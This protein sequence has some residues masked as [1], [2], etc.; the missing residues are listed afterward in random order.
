MSKHSRGF[1]WKLAF[2]NLKNN[3]R[4]Y[5]PYLLSSAGI[6]LMFYIICALV[7]GINQTT[8][9]GGT[10]VASM[11][12]LGQFVIGLFAVLFLFYTNSF[13]IKRRKKELGLYNIL[14]MEKQHIAKILFRETLL[15][16][17]ISLI[18]GLGLGILFS[19]VMFWLLGVMLGSTLPITF[20]IPG[21]AI[22]ATV[23]LF[24]CIFLLTL[25]YNLLQVKLSKP[26]E[27]LHGGE[28]G[29][30]E[31]KAHWI[32]AV[33]GAILLGTGYYMAVT[34]QDP[35]Q[36]LLFFFVAV[37][38]V[39]LGTYLLFI[40]GITALLKLLKKNKG[41]YYKTNHFTAISG[42]LFRMKQN[43]AGLAS[44]CV[45]F[46]ALLVTVSTTFSLYTSMDQLIRTRYPR[47][48]LISARGANEDA[49]EMIRSAVADQA[50]D[51]GLS[52]ENVVEQE[53][54]TIT[55]ARMGS[56][57]ST[58]EVATTTYAVAEIFTQ[59]EFQQF[60]GQDVEL[61]DNQVLFFDPFHTFP[62]GDSMTINNM[63]FSILTADYSFPD[64]STM[65]QIYETY[66]MVVKDA[67][68][69]NTII[70]GGD[71][72][73][74]ADF[75]PPTYSYDFDVAGGDPQDVK[76]MSQ[77]LDNTLFQG[78][79]VEYDSLMFEDSATS[80][81]DFL[82][83]YGGLF[84]LGMFL[85]V[86]FLLGTALIIY[87]KQVSEGYEDAKR[88]SIMQKVGM[89]HQEV[90]KSIHSQILL[91]FFLPLLTA[92]V[93][94]AF[95]FPMLQKILLIMGLA[96]FQLILFS[97]LGCVAVFALAYLI[98]YA[99]TARTY[100]NIVETTAD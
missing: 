99:F 15:T 51:L 50:E 86:L 22:L 75:V 10:S 39:I 96:D 52:L 29:E 28:A 62:A 3:R 83:L 24:G 73:A 33:L 70:A 21:S 26:I 76:A 53:G 31:P 45:L 54:W 67:A 68:V 63:E 60:S 55:M 13:I 89:S 44:I 46:T 20:L 56:R 69:V 19:R 35:L 49:K 47:N 18:L 65:A 88:F 77:A 74:P 91:V 12:Q 42:M 66:Y 27:L 23:I 48:V 85:G 4:V 17:G 14:G 11:L 5:L 71:T 93:H 58:Q 81:E 9:Y 2:S 59:E 6:I 41:F 25:C 80:R 64:V 32:L 8:M 97:T 57:F 90:K 7:P 1:Y 79:N 36:A 37:I 82:S 100:Y 84:F 34:I 30:K 16:A 43:A 95:A 72:P 98:I 40:T 87:Y 38:L 61:N 78:E 94:L 92:V